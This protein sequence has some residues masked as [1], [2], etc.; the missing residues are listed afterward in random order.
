MRSYDWHWRLE[1]LWLQTRVVHLEDLVLHNQ[2]VFF[3][4]IT[5]AVIWL[6]QVWRPQILRRN[7]DTTVLVGVFF[8]GATGKKTY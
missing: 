1:L 3:I 5:S 8:W 6:G 4:F 7:E 2:M